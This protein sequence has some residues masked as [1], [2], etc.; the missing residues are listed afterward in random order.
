[1]GNLNDFPENSVSIDVQA[2]RDYLT[3]AIMSVK[4]RALPQV[5]DGQKPVQKRIPHRIQDRKSV[6]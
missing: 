2:E 1:M 6:V 5:E 4:E 3:Y